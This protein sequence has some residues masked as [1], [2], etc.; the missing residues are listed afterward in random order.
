MP[1]KILLVDDSITTRLTNRTIIA[2]RTA[3]E[4][5]C[6]T[7]GPEAL[8]LV[9]SEKPDLIL[10]EVIRAALVEK[11]PHT[12]AAILTSGASYTQFSKVCF[13]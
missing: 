3:H 13:F 2:R 12:H 6:A 5:I 4:V 1:K 7:N 9:A 10:M 8:K 11:I